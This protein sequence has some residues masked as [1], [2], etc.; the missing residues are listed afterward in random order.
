MNKKFT[1]LFT[2]LAI[3]STAASAG[4]NYTY[5]ILGT[6]YKVDTLYHAKVGPGT[7]QTSLLFTGPTY[8]LRVFY[9]TVDLKTPNVSIRAV[10]GNDMVAGC[11]TTSSMAK[12]HDAPGAR[13]FCGVN[14]DFYA[15]GGTSLR[16]KSLVGTPTNASIVDGEIFK[17]SEAWKQFAVDVNGV[18][19][20]GFASFSQGTAVCGD[21]TVP[22]TGVNVPS[23][24]NAL[25]IYTPKYYGGTNMRT[26]TMSE[27]TV[28][29]ADGEKFQA[30]RSCKVVVTGTP[31]DAGD[32]DVP[33]DGFVLHGRGNVS[34][35]VSGLKAGDVVTLN[36]V[37]TIDGTKIVPEQ[38]VSGNPKT[39]GD[40]KTLDTENERGDASG[41]HP[42]TGIGYGDNKSKVIMMVVDG[43]SAISNGARTS[44]V[45]E[46]MRYAGAT[47]AI[48]LDGGGSSTCYTQAL[49][50]RNVPSDGSERSDGNA[51]FAVCSAPDDDQVAEIRFVDWAMEFPKYGQ[52][53]PKFYGYN[54]YGML[55][56]TDL[57]GVKLS[58]SAELGFVKEDGTT[59]V[60]NGSGTH[61]LTATYNGITTTIPVTIVSSTE[62]KMAHESV[63]NDGYRNYPVE[64]LSKVN[65]N[66][67]QID[68]GALTWSSDDAS[69]VEI[70]A[71][72]GVLKGVKDGTANVCGKVG[73]FEGKTQVVV[74]TPKS[75][76]MAIDPNTDPSTWTI[77]Q[78]GGTAGKIEA[79]GD[80][81]CYKY[82]GKSGRAP[83]IKLSKTFK[84][85]SLPDTLR[86]RINPGEAKI[87]NVILSL[88]SANG[89][90]ENM[91]ITPTFEAGKTVMIDV[92]MDTWCDPSNIAT[93]PVSLHY[94]YLS[95]GASSAG[96]EYTIEFPGFE[97]VYSA[98]GVGGVN[99]VSAD[100][101]FGVVKTSLLQGEPLALH[102]DKAG[103]ANVAVY[104]VAGQKVEAATIQAE[105]G[106]A[107]VSA[108]NLA[109]GIYFVSITQNGE[110]CVTK[111]IVK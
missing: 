3:F 101:G 82:T 78:T 4:G 34:S 52:Y 6:T 38:L 57:K 20:V 104:N 67:V 109:Q 53:V 30:G 40:G 27:V 74:E 84:L 100:K 88:A 17:T 18:P 77:S 111:I 36:S 1:S 50:I 72:T 61:A 63:I 87:S 102:F 98:V 33:S 68:P 89:V 28:K 79:M 15:T 46:L 58:C 25:T 73:D 94:I 106:M 96:K 26:S 14:G 107:Q 43:R 76:V 51:I 71:Q 24:N 35:F 5:D 83:Y 29:L 95:M 39:V 85:W 9:L 70:D 80:G 16:G 8:N 55:I 64:V 75:R 105:V 11:E 62:M 92:P 31:S 21:K 13:Y 54:K 65:E 99:Q 44:Q 22:F 41:Y 7:T 23:P 91:K 108:A 48:N 45:G 59:F 56:N 32:M 66:Y 19:Y 69:V 2:A 97:S 86:L 49:G 81:F 47:D 12:R 90:R 103:V 60:G 37:V 42:R 10:S 93:Y 110:N